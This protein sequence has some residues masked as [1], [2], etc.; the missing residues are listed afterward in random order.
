MRISAWSSDVCSSYL[1][2][3]S[4][5]AHGAVGFIAA[6]GGKVQPVERAHQQ[7]GAAVVGRIGVEDVALLV[8]DENA[9][10]EHVRAVA[11]GGET[12]VVACTASGACF[13][14][15]RNA[16]IVIEI[17]VFRGNPGEGPGHSLS[18][19]LDL[20]ARGARYR[21]E[22]QVGMFK[23]LS[24][25]VH[26]VHDVRTTGTEVIRAQIGRASCRER[27]CQYV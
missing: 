19:L 22:S 26:M 25:A 1:I 8:F 10:A 9:H 15:E 17:A 24:C 16:E 6:L 7:F 12:I 13:L 20:L 23:M 14:R 5:P 18:G 2:V 11:D 21:R 27:V 3:Q 4:N